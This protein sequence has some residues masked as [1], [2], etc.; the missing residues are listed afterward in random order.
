MG[1]TILIVLLAL[2][3]PMSVVNVLSDGEECVQKK[4]E[5]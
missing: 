1:T 2:Y 3:V 5:D 4:R